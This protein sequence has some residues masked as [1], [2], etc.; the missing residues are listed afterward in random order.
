MIGVNPI[1]SKN[2]TIVTLHLDDEECGSERLA[3]YGKLCGDDTFCLHW[4]APHAITRLVGLC[5]L[6]VFPSELLEDRVRH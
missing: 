1:I 3:R 5:K 4:I 2:N 6:V